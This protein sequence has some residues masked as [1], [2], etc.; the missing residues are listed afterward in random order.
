LLAAHRKMKITRS[1]INTLANKGMERAAPEVAPPHAKLLH[2]GT[3]CSDYFEKKFS[4]AL[5][6][7]LQPIKSLSV[8]VENFPHCGLRDLAFFRAL[9]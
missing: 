8:V 6:R 4:G 2:N 5:P 3:D 1:V 7:F 9:F